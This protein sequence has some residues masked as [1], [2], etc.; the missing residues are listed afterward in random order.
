MFNVSVLP[1]QTASLLYKF[2]P[3]KTLDS[4]E[5]GI[6]FDVYYLNPENDTFATTFFNDTI[7]I[8]EADE[9]FDAKS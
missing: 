3:D 8:Y 6:I 1:N 2:K 7:S 4:R 9:G 5:M